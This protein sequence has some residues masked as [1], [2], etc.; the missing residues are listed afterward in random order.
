VARDIF[1]IRKR[2]TRQHVIADQSM[3]YVERCIIDEGH[4]AQR[5]ESDYGYDLLLYTFNERGYAEPGMVYLQVK[6]SE[7]LQG[8]GT[9]YLFDVDV[10]DYNLWMGELMPVFLILFDASRRRAFWMDFQKYFAEESTRRPKWGARTVR[11][12]VSARQALNRRAVARMR[13]AKQVVLRSLKG[14]MGHA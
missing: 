2:R 1:S 3:N 11:V 12:R 9:D 6:A 10:R 8:S 4:V 5:Q 7:K 14:G 13:T